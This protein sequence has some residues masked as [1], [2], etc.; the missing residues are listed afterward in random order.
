MA[1]DFSKI[2][3]G[4][5]KIKTWLTGEFS[6][7][8]TGRASPL[9]LDSVMVESFGSRTPIKHIANISIEDAKTLRI[10]PWDT[11]NIKNIESAIAA[12]NLGV[13][14]SPDSSSL[15]VIFPD[16]TEERRKSLVKVTKEKLE[17]ARISVRKERDEVWSDIQKKEK[18]GQISEDDKFT[19]K[20]E[21]QK[22]IDKTNKDLEEMA[23]KKEK[24]ITS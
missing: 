13:S 5:E 14:T 2:K 22:L 6:L 18:D 12:S 20:E 21:L 7:V 4:L 19:Y 8:R 9:L 15:R 10:A 11:S 3:E 17:E 24:E 23:D 1:Y 16:L